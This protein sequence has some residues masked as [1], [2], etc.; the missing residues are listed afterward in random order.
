MAASTENA[1]TV[2][3]ISGIA[4]KD[5]DSRELTERPMWLGTVERTPSA[6]AGMVASTA[7]RNVQ[8]CTAG[9]LAAASLSLG[10]EIDRIDPSLLRVFV[11]DLDLQ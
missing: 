5:G 6:S 4:V 3:K 2:G 7:I 9:R 11:V 8:S 10:S 1:D